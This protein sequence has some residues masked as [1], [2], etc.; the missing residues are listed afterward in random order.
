M[1]GDE[2]ADVHKGKLGPFVFRVDARDPTAAA[3]RNHAGGAGFTG[4]YSG[5]AIP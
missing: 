1:T 4:R 3:R 5:Y 2:I